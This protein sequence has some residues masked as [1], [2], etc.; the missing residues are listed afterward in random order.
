M[1]AFISYILTAFDHSSSYP[2]FNSELGIE[3]INLQKKKSNQSLD[4]TNVKEI[5]L[6]AENMRIA[7][8]K[9]EIMAT[10]KENQQ[11]AKQ[12][13]NVEAL[14]L[15]LNTGQQFVRDFFLCLNEN[16]TNWP[17]LHL[18]PDVFIPSKRRGGGAENRR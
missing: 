5:L 9:S 18:P 17:D 13:E 16:V 7:L 12:L 11:L 4:P 2:N 10:C 8:R 14:R 6:D 15:N 3:L 1:L